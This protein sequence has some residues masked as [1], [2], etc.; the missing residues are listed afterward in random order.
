MF[1]AD[2]FF[3]PTGRKKKVDTIISVAELN[4]YLV[5]FQG[6]PSHTTIASSQQSTT[7]VPLQSQEPATLDKISEDIGAKA[8]VLVSKQSEALVN[9]ELE[10]TTQVVESLTQLS[11]GVNPVN[12]GG[13]INALS[14]S[15]IRKRRELEQSLEPR[16][17]DAQD[18][19]K[20]SFTLEELM[21]QWNF[22][23]ERLQNA[24][25]M[26]MS[27]L[28]GMTEPKLNGS[29]IALE[30]PNQGSKLSFDENKYDLVNYLRKKLNNYDIEIHIQVNEQIKL[31]KKVLDNKDRYQRFMELNSS[32]DFLRQVFELDLK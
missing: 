30:L 14:L 11:T 5:Q 8:E 2:R 7:G 27:S 19:P 23:S 15:S 29:I 1:N 31:A 4:Q 16:V 24:G 26:L 18:L 17:L 22:Y 32:I 13:T 28:M 6:S 3:S 9:N 10:N 25:S 20:Q 12:K 21:H